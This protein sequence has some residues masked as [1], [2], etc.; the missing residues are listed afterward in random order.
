VRRLATL[1]LFSLILCACQASFP[2]EVQFVGATREMTREIPVTV[3]VTQIVEIEVPVTVQVTSIVE[4][5]IVITAT[6][7]PTATRPPTARP[8]P[9]A[10]GPTPTPTSPPV[11]SRSNPVRLGEPHEFVDERGRRLR[12]R[13]VRAV[14]GEEARQIVNA[15][16]S[17]MTWSPIEGR[18][19]LVGD[20]EVAYLDGPVDTLFGIRGMDF[21]TEADNELLAHT[22]FLSMEGKIEGAFYPGGQTSGWTVFQVPIGSEVRGI[23]YEPLFGDIEIW[24]AVQ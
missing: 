11:G 17:F 19:F 22:I 6:P 9:T 3:Q 2:P 7:E 21:T 18:E 15:G 20:F 5:E 13:L 14:R 12:L 24:F 1:V 4:R 16:D 8:T 23:Y 10:T